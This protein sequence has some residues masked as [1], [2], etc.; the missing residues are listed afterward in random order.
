MKLIDR[1]SLAA[2]AAAAALAALSV[3]IW[4][5]L[6]RLNR[7]ADWLTVE[8]PAYAA[9]GQPLPLKITVKKADVPIWLVVDLH[10]TDRSRESAGFLSTGGRRL[11][12]APG[13]YPF[14]PRVAPRADLAFVLAVVYLSRTGDWESRDRSATTDLIRVRSGTAPAAGAR[15]SALPAY[16]DGTR[17]AV[18]GIRAGGE[19]PPWNE[20]DRTAGKSAVAGLLLAAAVAAAWSARAAAGRERTAWAAMAAVLAAATA[21]ELSGAGRAV[22]ELGR[23][24]AASHD[25]YYLRKPLQAGVIA[26]LTAGGACAAVLVGRARRSLGRPLTVARIGA[27]LYGVVTAVDLLSFHATDA[28]AGVSVAGLPLIQVLKL[29]N[30]ALVLAAGVHRGL[31]RRFRSLTR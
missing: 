19:A 4:L 7:R 14:E 12:D 21:W 9:A 6:D 22:T 17:V 30:A 1:R 31:R 8:A 2:A 13:T 15:V 20:A 25:W 5:A 11:L 18:A 27:L 28:I 16:E 23:T 10:W 3:A 26:A 29:A 24:I